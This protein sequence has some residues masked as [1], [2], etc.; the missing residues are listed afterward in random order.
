MET[1]TETSPFNIAMVQ[2]DS[3]IKSLKTLNRGI[4]TLR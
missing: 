3:N 1:S 4:I 2:I